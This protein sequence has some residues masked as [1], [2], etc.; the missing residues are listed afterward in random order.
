MMADISNLLINKSIVG[1]YHNYLEQGLKLF[2][3][4][5][6][7]FTFRGCTIAYAWAVIAQTPYNLKGGIPMRR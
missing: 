5:N 7:Y 6:S 1:L 4:D 3:N 2:L